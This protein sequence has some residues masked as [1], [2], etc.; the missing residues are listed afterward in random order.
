MKS[1][2]YRYWQSR[3]VHVR[4][5]AVA[6]ITFTAYA[7][8]DR[9]PNVPRLQGPLVPTSTPTA[10]TTL[11]SGAMPCGTPRTEAGLSSGGGF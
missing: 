6:E 7:L 8:K 5:Q 1:E 3:P 11:S 4:I 10:L 9:A 2:E